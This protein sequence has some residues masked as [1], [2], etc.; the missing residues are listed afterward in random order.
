[1]AWAISCEP[2]PGPPA[3]R[4]LNPCCANPLRRKASIA[5]RWF[6]LRTR[7]PT[8]TKYFRLGHSSG[9]DATADRS[10]KQHSSITEE[11]AKSA[12][13][14][15]ANSTLVVSLTNTRCGFAVRMFV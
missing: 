1:M 3:I 5:R 12:P 10:E 7:E 8:I 9:F 14:R 2:L 13:N 11:D 6:F 4:S 15:R